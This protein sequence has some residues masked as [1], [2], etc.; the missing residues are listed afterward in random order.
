MPRKIEVVQYEAAFPAA[1]AI[2]S[3]F[4]YFL[5]HHTTK[6]LLVALL[7]LAGP[8]YIGWQYFTS[9]Q[10]KIEALAPES[11]ADTGSDFRIMD[12]AIAAPQEGL[13]I[14]IKGERYGYYD[15]SF[16]I[17]KVYGKPKVVIYDAQSDVVLGAEIPILADR[18]R[19]KQLKK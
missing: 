13:P 16:Q 9:E 15:P 6:T 18:D 19:M 10:V 17:W 4:L 3:G 7:M 14:I 2:I 11:Q 5:F 12:E 1:V 8:V